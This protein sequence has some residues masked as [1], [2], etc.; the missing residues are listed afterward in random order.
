MAEKQNITLS[1][2]RDLLNRV[3]RLAADRETSISALLVEALSRIVN[4]DRR[5]S[6]ARKLVLAAFSS[7]RSLGTGG[8]ATWTRDELYERPLTRRAL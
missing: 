7:T 1:L 4:E 6:E 3:K 2:P 5:Y 8:Q